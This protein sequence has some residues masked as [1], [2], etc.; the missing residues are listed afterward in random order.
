MLYKLCTYEDVVM[1][2]RMFEMNHDVEV[3]SIKARLIFLSAGDVLC[4]SNQK[5]T[6]SSP[7]DGGSRLQ[8]ETPLRTYFDVVGDAVFAEL[9]ELCDNEDDVGSKLIVSAKQCTLGIS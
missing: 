7:L 8:L 9:D 6:T 1:Q 3:A 5:G 4:T 2:C